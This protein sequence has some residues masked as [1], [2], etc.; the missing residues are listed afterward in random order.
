MT[1]SNA[2]KIILVSPLLLTL[3]ACA[4]K[5]SAQATTSITPASA[6]GRDADVTLIKSLQREHNEVVELVNQA[7]VPDRGWDQTKAEQFGRWLDRL[8]QIESKLA[9]L[10]ATYAAE[11][12]SQGHA[13]RI[14]GQ[15]SALERATK[16]QN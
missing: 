2:L 5:R 16:T 6:Q 10:D 9:T 12:R 8:D 14:A 4:E 15:R 11:M 1:K 7:G 13:D 3:I